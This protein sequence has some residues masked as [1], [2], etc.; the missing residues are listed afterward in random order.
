MLSLPPPP[1]GA[2]KIGE[3]HQYCQNNEVI[4]TNLQEDP[5]QRRELFFIAFEIS[6]YNKENAM[7]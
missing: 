4:S 1:G 7:E 5:Y 3:E 6:Q 2:K